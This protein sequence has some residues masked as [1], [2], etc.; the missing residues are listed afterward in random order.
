MES[1]YQLDFLN[2]NIETRSK[3]FRIIKSRIDEA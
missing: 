2:E 1:T 3:V